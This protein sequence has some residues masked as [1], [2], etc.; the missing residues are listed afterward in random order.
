MSTLRLRHVDSVV[1]TATLSLRDDEQ[2]D[3][4]CR[5]LAELLAD[6]ADKQCR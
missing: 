1:Y 6:V 3:V 2:L 4:R 5:A